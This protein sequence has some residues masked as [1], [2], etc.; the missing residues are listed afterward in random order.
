MN[1]KF[2]NLPIEKQKQSI[3]VALIDVF[4]LPCR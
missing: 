4:M 3:N 2:F 1:D